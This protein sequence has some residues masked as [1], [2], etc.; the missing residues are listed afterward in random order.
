MNELKTILLIYMLFA[1]TILI[2]SII[3]WYD[4]LRTHKQI[5]LINNCL[6]KQDKSLI[7]NVNINSLIKKPIIAPWSKMKWISLETEE[8]KIIKLITE[9]IFK[10]FKNKTLIINE[11]RK[12]RKYNPVFFQIEGID[13]NPLISKLAKYKTYENRIIIYDPHH[14]Y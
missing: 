14:N 9:N 10:P 13:V 12:F 2:P 6:I 5:N 11:Y 8:Y 1:L 3:I 4:N 7:T